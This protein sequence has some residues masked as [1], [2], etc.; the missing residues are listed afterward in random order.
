[1]SVVSG[2]GLGHAGVCG[3]K[4]NG[5]RIPCHCGDLVVSDTTLRADDPVTTTR[6]L[7]DGL[8]VRAPSTAESL[9]LNLAGLSIVGRG[10]GIGLRIDGGGSDG[11]RIIGGEGTARGEIVGFGIGVFS[12]RSDA[13]S[14]VENLAVKGNRRDGLRLR[15]SGALII[16]LETVDNGGDGLHLSGYGGRIV[17]IKAA[18]NRE[19]GVRLRTR[20]TLISG[21]AV[22]NSGHGIVSDGAGNDISGMIALDNGGAGVIARGGRQKTAG[23]VSE[24]NALGELRRRS[25]ELVE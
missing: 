8:I 5:V 21:Q 18:G 23:V 25:K 9:V 10:D 2:P 16:N 17:N 24:G 22:A 20:D 7:L 12:P 15:S 11:V 13:L 1:V 6:C 4:V 14:R 3:D 19:V